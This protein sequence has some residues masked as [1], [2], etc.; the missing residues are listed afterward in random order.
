M[1]LFVKLELS[2]LHDLLA[3][4]AILD[5]SKIRLDRSNLVRIIFSTE[6]PTQPKPSLTF[7]VLYFTPS[8]KGKILATF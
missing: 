6:F 5:R 1:R 8:I 2:E 3:K 7:R 4:S